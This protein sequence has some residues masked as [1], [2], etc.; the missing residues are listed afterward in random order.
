MAEHQDQTPKR[1][2]E[3]EVRERKRIN[4]QAYKE[5]YISFALMIIFTILAF[6]AIGSETIDT[7]FAVYFILILAVLQFVFQ[8]FVFMH[9]K[10]RGSG[11]PV[12]FMSA[13]VFVAI[14]T[15]AALVHVRTL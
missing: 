9:L 3:K 5:V 13:G 2:R 7:T 4:T 12:F 11:Y 8:L 15:V 14:L 1:N 6:Y 10:E